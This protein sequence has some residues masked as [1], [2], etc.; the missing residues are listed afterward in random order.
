LSWGKC[1]GAGGAQGRVPEEG[2]LR[3]GTDENRR[4]GLVGL[5][6]GQYKRRAA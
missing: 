6:R 1:L 3:V 5:M 4:A 2:A